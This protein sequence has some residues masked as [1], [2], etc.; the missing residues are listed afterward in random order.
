M[1]RWW[2]WLCAQMTKVENFLR[3]L[4]VEK[5]RCRYRARRFKKW[6]TQFP[7]YL[8]CKRTSTIHDGCFRDA[9]RRQ[10]YEL[11]GG[12]TVVV[13]QGI[14][15]TYQVVEVYNWDELVQLHYDFDPSV[16][17]DWRNV[18]KEGGIYG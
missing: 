18:I 11:R 17:F 14:C 8:V 4:F 1:R 9:E 13:R 6:D 7:P 12:L 2:N 3:E 15:Q 16:V 10:E 5:I